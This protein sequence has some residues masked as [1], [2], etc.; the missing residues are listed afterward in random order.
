MGALLPSIS[1]DSRYEAF[2]SGS[3]V[4]GSTP[5][6]S[7]LVNGLTV[8]NDALNVYVHDRY[9]NTTAC[10]S[11]NAS[12]NVTG[13]DQ[14]RFPVVSANGRYVVFVSNATDLTSIDNNRNNPNHRQNVFVRDLLTNG[15]T[16]VSV[17]FKGSGP[18]TNTSND[19]STSRNP[20]ISADGRYVAF[21]SDAVDLVPNDTNGQTDVFVRDIQAGTTVLASVNASGANGGDASSTNPVISS[22]GSAV[23][24]DSLANDLDPSHTGLAPF[25]SFQVY[26]RDLRKNA[27]TLVSVDSS[28]R[29]AANGASAAPSLSADGKRVAFQSSATNIVASPVVTNSGP[30]V[31]LRDLATG[32]TQLVSVNASGTGAGSSGSFAPDLSG[33]GHHVVFSSLANDLT[34]GLVAPRNVFERDLFSNT[35]RLI[36]VNASGTAGGNNASDL[37]NQGFLNS[38]QQSSGLVSDDGRYV[39]FMSLATDLVPGFVGRN[40]RAPAIT[41]TSATPRAGRPRSS[42]AR[43]GRPPPAATTPL[44]PPPR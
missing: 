13:N 17:N 2:E 35:T 37:P 10:A 7:D 25:T 24:F 8:A 20:S 44:S 15:T 18:A 14:S 33:D 12:G 31:Y 30:N 39:L 38:G 23:V 29:L 42:P 19:L 9:S 1:A 28:G 40:T 27:T 6:P 41:C 3:F 11:V 21:E 34:A 22:D 32:R 36:S 4:G 5:A 43:S 26:A 16:L